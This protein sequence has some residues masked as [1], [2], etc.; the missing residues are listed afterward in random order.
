MWTSCSALRRQSLGVIAG[1]FEERAF[2]P[3]PYRVFPISNVLSAFRYMADGDAHQQNS[4]V[5]V[6]PPAEE[7]MTFRPDGT[8]RIASGLD[9]FSLAVVQ[10]LVKNGAKHLVLMRLA[11]LPQ[12]PP[13]QR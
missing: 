12:E 1:I 7:K 9:G 5:M 13:S 4:D 11:V 2:H 10:W 3:I 6:A 8:C